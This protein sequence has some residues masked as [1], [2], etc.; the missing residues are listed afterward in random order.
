[1]SRVGIDR[2]VIKTYGTITG[3]MEPCIIYL[4]IYYCT[5]CISTD[6]ASYK[7]TERG[8]MLIR[9]LR[10]LATKNAEAG[11]FHFCSTLLRDLCIEMESS[12][13]GVEK[14]ALSTNSVE[15]FLVNHSNENHLS[16]AN[17]RPI[18]QDVASKY[19]QLFSLPNKPCL[20]TL[21]AITPYLIQNI[22]EIYVDCESTEP[23]NGLKGLSKEKVDHFVADVEKA[24]QEE[25][26][27]GLVFLICRV[28]EKLSKKNVKDPVLLEIEEMS[29]SLEIRQM[30]KP[31]K[32]FFQHSRQDIRL[33]MRL[34]LF[35]RR[36]RDT[37]TRR[38]EREKIDVFPLH[39]V[40]NMLLSL[41]CFAKHD[42]SKIV[43][44][45][46]TDATN[47]PLSCY[48]EN[49]TY[50]KPEATYSQM[51]RVKK[52]SEEVLQLHAVALV[53]IEEDKERK[54]REIVQREKGSFQS[55]IVLHASDERA[56]DRCMRRHPNIAVLKL[57]DKR[58][59]N[60]RVIL[61]SRQQEK[62][63]NVKIALERKLRLDFKTSKITW[64]GL[65]MASIESETGAC[66]SL[67]LVYKWGSERVVL[68]SKDFVTLANCS[69][70]GPAFSG[71]ISQLVFNK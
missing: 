47:F 43:R 48:P 17:R 42:P 27:E 61:C 12:A 20:K 66:L 55:E 70:G 41:L 36:L 22:K 46:L 15:Y 53:H 40:R 67:R 11:L 9:N 32:R 21:L 33:H 63:F 34:H 16:S 1:M 71:G 64:Y 10:E 14:A 3:R 35:S 23:Q 18:P 31:L 50:N 57:K 51:F 19:R 62:L 54:K 29:E 8:Q 39:N 28:L 6:Q 52:E 5:N 37:L 49:V 38:A 24:E 45:E 68:D 13:E 59:G 60:L 25:D 58:S 56:F 69:V 30:L 4:L 2:Q 65:K 7:V 26:Y 44:F